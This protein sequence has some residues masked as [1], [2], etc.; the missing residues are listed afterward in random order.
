MK[1]ERM[2]LKTKSGKEFLVE[3]YWN[4][5]TSSIVMDGF[6]D[7]A[8]DNKEMEQEMVEAMEKFGN[9]FREWIKNGFNFIK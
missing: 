8:D 7:K 9:E 3:W 1:K 4:D 2:M 5:E 6:Y